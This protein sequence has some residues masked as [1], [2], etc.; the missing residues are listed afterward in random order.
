MLSYQVFGI[1]VFIYLGI[2]ALL[3]LLLTAYLAITR[4]PR[5]SF[6]KWHHYMVGLSIFLVLLHAFSGMIV[7]GSIGDIKNAYNSNKKL[8]RQSPEISAGQKIF[9]EICSRCHAKGYNVIIPNLP[10]RGS[11]KLINYETFLS[12]IRDP[13]MP[14]GSTGPMPS[15]PESNLSNAET[16]NLYNYLIFEYGQ[17]PTE[18]SKT[19]L[20]LS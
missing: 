2:F 6:M 1:S 8:M 3:S 19:P 12:F 11:N 15:F 14:D 13:R 20:T 17:K 10:I 7:T 4:K 16:K 9:D 5:A 18:N